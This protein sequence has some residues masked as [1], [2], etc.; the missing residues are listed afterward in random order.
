MRFKERKEIHRFVSSQIP[1]SWKVLY[2]PIIRNTVLLDFFAS[3]VVPSALPPF[4]IGWGNWFSL[5]SLFAVLLSFTPVRVIMSEK[6]NRFAGSVRMFRP[7]APWKLQNSINII[8]IGEGL[9]FLKWC[10][11]ESGRLWHI[12]INSHGVGCCW[13]TF[14]KS[15]LLFFS[16]RSKVFHKHTM[17]M[18]SNDGAEMMNRC[19]FLNYVVQGDLKC[20]RFQPLEPTFKIY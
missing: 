13:N 6:R 12:F 2:H 16:G 17:T 10:G 5:W 11:C 3:T 15:R 18:F 19:N 4:I 9:T 20:K 1:S 8:L 7:F 14:I